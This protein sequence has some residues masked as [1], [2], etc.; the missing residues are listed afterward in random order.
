M[1]SR[2]VLSWVFLL[3]SPCL[4]L[5]QDL[6]Q[7]NAILFLYHLSIL[8]SCFV[9]SVPIF[10]TKIVLHPLHPVA[11]LSSCILHLLVDRIFLRYFETFCF[12]CIDWVSLLSPISFDLSL[13]VLLSDLFCFFH[14][15][16]SL[17]VF[18]SLVLSH[19]GFAFLFG[20]PKRILSLT[21]T[22]FAPA[23]IS[24]F[25]SVMLHIGIFSKD[26][27]KYFFGFYLHIFPVLVPEGW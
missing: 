20:F 3:A 23:K 11:D 25:T 6:F 21:Q 2:T 10:Y 1:F 8:S 12:V 13:I 17:R 22:S 27:Q 18:P 5:P 19:P 7:V 15:Y 14:L 24:S 16:I 26:F 9:L 4:C